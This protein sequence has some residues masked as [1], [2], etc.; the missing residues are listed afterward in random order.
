MLPLK[1]SPALQVF[2]ETWFLMYGLML[3]G[4]DGA[5]ML[6]IFAKYL[7]MARG[8]MYPNTSLNPP[9]PSTQRVLQHAA[10]LRTLPW[11]CSQA[12]PGEITKI[13]NNGEYLP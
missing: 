13:V 8:I 11:L 12:V 7:P 9:P 3:A 4:M 2:V 10:A 5:G 6:F 1:P